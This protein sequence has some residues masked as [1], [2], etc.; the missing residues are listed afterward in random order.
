MASGLHSSEA[1]DFYTYR[2]VLLLG[3]LPHR[4]GFRGLGVQGLQV[5]ALTRWADTSHEVASGV[6][7]LVR[8][9]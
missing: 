2:F 1:Y 3:G 4:L 6:A 5:R 7:D 9:V 8:G